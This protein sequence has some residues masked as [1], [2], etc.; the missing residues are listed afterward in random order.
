MSFGERKDGLPA[1]F[2]LCLGDDFT[3]EGM[4]LD[5]ASTFQKQDILPFRD[6][7]C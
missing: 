7:F 2:V 6:S 3:D 4:F 5:F 1:D